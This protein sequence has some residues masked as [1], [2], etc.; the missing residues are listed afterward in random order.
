M[1]KFICKIFGH[2][3]SIVNVENRTSY[4]RRCGVK[5]SVSYDMS[6]GETIIEGN[7]DERKIVSF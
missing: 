2:Q 4:C 7:F 3:L 6:Y 1:K 5:L